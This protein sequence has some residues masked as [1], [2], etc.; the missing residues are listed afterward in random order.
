MPCCVHCAALGCTHARTRA[1]GMCTDAAAN[2]KITHA[3]THIHTHPSNS[4]YLSQ[5]PSVEA[6]LAAELDA[7]GLLAT[8]DRP[9]PRALTYADISGLPYLAAVIK[10]GMRLQ[11]VVPMCA[12]SVAFCVVGVCLMA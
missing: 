1:H 7:A 4:Y 6:K 8:R 2:F 3:R 5:H 10:E 11:P 12:G 9:A